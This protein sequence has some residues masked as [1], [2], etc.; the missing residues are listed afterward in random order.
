M[1]RLTNPFFRPVAKPADPEQA[2]RTP[3]EAVRA[4]LR[5]RAA[6][7]T[8]EETTLRGLHPALA[9]PPVWAQVQAALKLTVV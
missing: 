8:C 2:R 7:A 6:K 1:P 9:A 4:F 5:T 3:E